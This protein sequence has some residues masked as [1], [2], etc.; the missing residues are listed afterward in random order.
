MGDFN[1]DL[2]DIGKDSE[3]FLTVMHCIG[4]SQVISSPTRLNRNSASLID[5]LYTNM[6]MFNIHA[7]VIEA[8]VS[9]H[10]PI[11]TVFESMFCFKSIIQTL[12]KVVRSYKHYDVD[13]YC[14]DL[15]NARWDY[16]YKCK[17]VNDA[18][19][20]FYGIFREIC[21]KH[22]PLRKNNST[23][24]SKCFPKNPWVTKAILKSIKKKYKLYK[25]YRSSNFDQ[26]YERE[27][28]VYRNILTTVL[29]NAKRVY[30]SNMFNDNKQDSGKTWKIVNKLLN[31]GKEHT[32]SL[33]IEELVVSKVDEVKSIFF[34]KRNSRRA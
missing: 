8:D 23:S 34:C 1:I 9:D 31:P 14:L 28:K 19:S 26:K 30:Y 11:F 27:Y 13:L 3:N 15:A 32:A 25:R 17:D 10:L 4:L 5:H 24:H 20:V 21:D 29:K 7:G 6:D 18:Y 22:A 2:I 33:E 16:V 12:G